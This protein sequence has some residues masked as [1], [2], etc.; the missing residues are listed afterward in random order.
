MDYFIA[1]GKTFIWLVIVVLATTAIILF[2]AYTLPSIV[3]FIVEN[4]KVL[5]A[6]VGFSLLGITTVLVFLG[7]LKRTREKRKLKNLS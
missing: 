2:E 7:N 4:H 3:S 5:L 6:T 1:A